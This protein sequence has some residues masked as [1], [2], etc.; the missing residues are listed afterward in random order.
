M[1]NNVIASMG[2]CSAASLNIYEVDDWGDF[3]RASI[4]N[5]KPRKYKLYETNK[6]TYFNFGG[7]RY[8]LNEFIRVNY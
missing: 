6:G 7:C 2:L 1:N 4:N 8:Y 5:F 3:V